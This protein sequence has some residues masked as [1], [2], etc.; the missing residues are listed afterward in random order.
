MI[1]ACE[2]TQA[3]HTT[4]LLFSGPDYWSQLQND[5]VI[6]KGLFPQFE[7]PSSKDH[8]A[9]WEQALFVFDTNVLLN[10]YR[11]QFPTRNELLS[12]LQR[13]SD[14]IW[15]PHHVALEFQRNRLTVIADQ[16]RR[17]ADVRKAVEKA[18]SG[19]TADLESLQL[20]NRHSSINPQPIIDTITKVVS[21]FLIE[22]EQ[23]R[24]SQ[25]ILS[26]QD[27][28]KSRIEDLFTTKVGAAPHSQQELDELYK[29]AETRFKRKTPPGY[30]DGNKDK[31]AISEYVAGGV[32]YQR[33]YGDFL[34]WMQ[35]LAH[36]KS[37]LRHSV[38]FVTDD[39][40][41]DWWLKVDEDGPKTIGPRPELIEEAKLSA[42]IQS[43]LMYSPESFL[44]YS[45]E[46]LKTQV[47]DDVLQEIRD[48]STNRSMSDRL[49]RD[50]K[51]FPL[52]AESS[53]LHWLLQR[54]N[55]L[56]EGSS[57]FPDFIVPCDGRLLAFEVVS[58][59]SVSFT[60]RRLR[61]LVVQADR[62]IRDGKFSQVTLVLVSPYSGT[63]TR[64]R[65][66]ALRSVVDNVPGGICFVTG[67]LAD[68]A[69]ARDEFV[70][71]EEFSIGDRFPNDRSGHGE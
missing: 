54:F 71:F 61:D 52:R 27:P 56:R 53:V 60:R 50:G 4:T 5:G 13:L 39:A 32:V 58:V 7:E 42:G 70:V 19:L 23:L 20:R 40:K 15:I 10:L 8:R 28:L 37:A 62:A 47:S 30:A 9:I 16:N 35:I 57:G 46:F 14:R 2:L 59:R 67:T 66:I 38:I 24:S 18:R 12:I 3:A 21:D 44:K 63:G 64:L 48:V 33:R 43:F 31:D 65:E 51:D 34:V 45:G 68:D 36:A 11:Y 26:A 41:E 17:F 69:S 6:M 29:L 49:V 55:T 25:Q 22:L 1:A